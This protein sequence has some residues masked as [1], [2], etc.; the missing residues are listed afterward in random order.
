MPD[1]HVVPLRSTGVWRIHPDPKAL[2]SHPGPGETW[3]NRFDDPLGEYRVRYFATTR[4]GAFLEILGWWR[5]EQQTRARLAAVED[6]DETVEP[7]LP[8]GVT[9][10]FLDALRQAQATVV[11]ASDMFVDVAD[12]ETHQTLGR[13]GRVRLALDA[14]GLGATGI[15]AQLD[16]G[17]IRL[18][19]PRGRL[20]TQ[21]VSRVVFAETEFSGIRYTSRFDVREECWA[22][23]DSVHILFSDPEPISLTDP[24]LRDAAH[25]LGVRL[26]DP[27]GRV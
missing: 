12:P 15:P 11:G 22:V 1:L 4:R 21:A 9:R 8:D 6:I 7:P 17:T 27:E 16:E 10:T 3:P 24:D 5:T 23:F 14:S 13:H 25:I 19:G 18:G 26:P 20:I 2:P